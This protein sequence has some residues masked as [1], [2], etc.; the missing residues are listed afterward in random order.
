M[1]WFDANDYFLMESTLRPSLQARIDE[2]D[3]EPARVDRDADDRDH[4]RDCDDPDEFEDLVCR[5]GRRAERFRAV[6][7]LCRQS[8]LLPVVCDDDLDRRTDLLG[9]RDSARGEVLL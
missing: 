9:M 2:Q 4:G 1:P 6:E 5:R 7:A 8:L 3:P